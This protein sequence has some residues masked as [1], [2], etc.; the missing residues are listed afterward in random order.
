MS[1]RGYMAGPPTCSA[2]FFTNAQTG[3]GRTVTWAM[4][5]VKVHCAELCAQLRIVDHCVLVV[6]NGSSLNWGR[7]RRLADHR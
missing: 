7:G 2:D 5:R 4:R 6:L 1:M 3:A